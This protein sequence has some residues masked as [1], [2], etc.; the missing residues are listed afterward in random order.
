MVLGPCCILDKHNSTDNLSGGKFVKRAA[1]VIGQL[2]TRN[3]LFGWPRQYAAYSLLGQYVFLEALTCAPFTVLLNANA[4]PAS[5]CSKIRRRLQHLVGLP[6]ASVPKH[7]HS[8]FSSFPG[9]R[10]IGTILTTGS[11]RSLPTALL[12]RTTLLR[13]LQSWCLS[14]CCASQQPGVSNSAIYDVRV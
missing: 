14:M 1:V 5:L 4:L 8:A 12:A 10:L 6:T 11:H 13:E 2:F 3:N 9:L 7:P